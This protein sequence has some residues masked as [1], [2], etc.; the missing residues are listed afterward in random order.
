MKYIAPI[1]L[2]SLLVHQWLYWGERRF[3][4][5]LVAL[6]VDA[7]GRPRH[8]GLAQATFGV[9]TFVD[10]LPPESISRCWRFSCRRLEA[11][12][13]ARW[14]FAWEDELGYPC[15]STV[16]QHAGGHIEVTAYQSNDSDGI[17]VTVAPGMFA[18]TGRQKIRNLPSTDLPAGTLRTSI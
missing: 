18:P 5:D 13:G 14:T 11:L 6:S 1:V 8:H 4:S 9:N 10:D 12:G 15:V 16:V 3:Q 17:N 2:A 7:L